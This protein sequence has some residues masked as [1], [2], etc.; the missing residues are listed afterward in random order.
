MEHREEYNKLLNSGVFFELYPDLTGCWTV[1][2]YE[3]LKRRGFITDDTTISEKIKIALTNITNEDIEPMTT[4]KYTNL[5]LRLREID[6]KTYIDVHNDADFKIYPISDLKILNANIEITDD[7][8]TVEGEKVCYVFNGYLSDDIELDKVEESAF[9]IVT[10]T[11]FNLRRF[12]FEQYQRKT[13]KEGWLK[14]KETK[15]IKIIATNFRIR[16]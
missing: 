16:W 2:C 10:D 12:K 8:V 7:I 11:K 3:W 15:P 6:G 9:E 5:H 13:L 4:K 1:D 14:L